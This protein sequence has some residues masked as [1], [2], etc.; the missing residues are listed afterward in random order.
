MMVQYHATYF[1]GASRRDRDIVINGAV[2]TEY[3]D[4]DKYSTPAGLFQI[5]Q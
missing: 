1:F 3:R 2:P 4:I 5:M